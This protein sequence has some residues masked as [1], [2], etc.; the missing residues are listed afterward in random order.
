MLSPLMSCRIVERWP[1]RHLPEGKPVPRCL[2]GAEIVSIG[3]AE[4]DGLVPG[5]G[6]FID[7]R[8]YKTRILRRLVLGFTE[9]GMWVVKN[10]EHSNVLEEKLGP[11]A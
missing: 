4:E 1:A 8:E 3:T 9:A 7:F 10:G 2:I 11:I 6:L 5:G